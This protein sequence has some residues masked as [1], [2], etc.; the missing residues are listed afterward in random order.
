MKKRYK[1][2]LL[3]L[4]VAALIA[5]LAFFFLTGS[6]FLTSAVL[7]FLSSR[8]GV[9]ISAERVEWS[10]FRSRLSV[11]KLRV[12]PEEQPY[13]RAGKAEAH[14]ALSTLAGGALKL[15]GVRME[16]SELTLYHTGDGRWSIFH[17]SPPVSSPGGH[18]SGPSKPFAIDLKD[19]VFRDSRLRLIF[20]DPEAGSAL[21]LTGLRLTA[22]RFANGRPLRLEAEGDLRLASSRANH[23]DAGRFRLGFD[24]KLGAGLAPET[25][26]TSCSFSGLFG[27]IS[28]E[29]FNDG[30][31]ELSFEG[32]R[33]PDGVALKKLTLM[34]SQ[35][36]TQQSEVEI[37]GRVR[38]QPLEIEADI[39][40]RRLS[41]EVTSLLFDLGFG[42]NPG[43]AA[44]QYRGNFSYGKRKLVASGI[45]R[46]DRT[47]DAI[48]DLER[49]TLPPLRLDGE[50]DFAIDL[51]ESSIDL[52]KFAVTLAEKESE[53]ASFRLQRPIRYSWKE[54]AQSAGQRA[55]FDLEC[56][57]FDLKLL[58]FL[59]PGNSAFQF[60]SGYFTS[61][62]QLTLKHNLSAFS[63]LGT[64]RVNGSSCR[65]NGRKFELAEIIAGLDVELRRDFHWTLRNLSLALKNDDADLGSAN[66]SGEGELTDLAGAFSG[67]LEG[68]TPELAVWL[69]PALEPFLPEYRKL[70]LGAAEIVF[71]L[72][73][74]AQNE[75]LLLRRLEAGIDRDGVRALELK[76]G[77]YRF[78]AAGG[79]SPG[80]LKVQLTGELPVSAMNV[81]LGPRMR[82]GSG[83]VKLSAE[84]SV[85][86]SFRSAVFS[87]ELA[88]DELAA[89]AYGRDYRDFS[90]Q[91]AFS[92][93]MPT[94]SSIEF[95]TL[96]FYLRRLGK[97]ALR[98]ECPGTWDLGR[99]SYSGDWAI[100]YLND[101]FLTLLAPGTVSEAQL[102]GK[103]QVVARENFRV[104][105]GSGAL[106]LDKLVMPSQPG[107]VYTGSFS[108]MAEKDERR[109]LLRH[110]TA[111][112]K[113]GEAQLFD[114]AGECRADLSS[115]E[116]GVTVQLA[117]TAV[118]AGKL[119]ALFPVRS[120]GGTRKA[121]E[122]PRLDFGRRPVDLGCRL[123]RIRFTPALAVDLDTRIRLRT[124]SFLTD[125][126]LL[127]I[128]NARY[129]GEFH[130]SNTAK[131]ILFSA[132]LRGSEPLSLPPLMELIVGSS[133][134]GA[135]GTLR[136][137]NLNLRF[138]EDGRPD[139]YLE[140]MSGS[141]AMS[142]RN[143][144]IPN[145][146]TNGPF[147]RLLLFPIEMTGQLNSLLPEDIAAWKESVISSESLKK[148]L[149]MVRLDEGSVRLHANDGKVRVDECAFFGDW[150]SRL[151]FSGTFDL[152]GER[153]L[154]LVSKLTVGGIQTTIPIEGTLDN[155]LVHLESIATGS[156]GALLNKVK[157]LKL[158][159]TSADPSDPNKIE[160]VIMIDKLPSAGTIKELQK[161]F[162]GLWKN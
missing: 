38:F 115:P 91:C 143:L 96:N 65:W 106:D 122:V 148:Q 133:Q 142:F 137:F 21:E 138:L 45:L 49:I 11:D 130:G 78:G 99:A 92:C 128:N 53:A 160:P 35:G 125:H 95:R 75:P 74:A 162:K 61:R 84:G 111:G 140:T 81:Y 58:R 82:F 102:T 39:D 161:L 85:A 67:R 144:T 64:G 159:G 149:K 132:A 27:S 22:D 23:I 101:Q 127:Q 103:M 57:A 32:S 105:R 5:V 4:L 147:G 34:Q 90:A 136:E 17:G 86:H 28:G 83:K 42:F 117:S 121:D 30:A 126:L 1:I 108:L 2:T 77:P 123:Q 113:Q 109:L 46:A 10:L 69:C 150:V 31:L 60:D 124:G 44:L 25:F 151:A 131:G 73:K 129:D 94:M 3:T 152:A 20:G 141:L 139:S 156:L 6:F 157:E 112:L 18:A 12:G 87:G 155:P 37:S 16:Q 114:L 66:F 135:A 62:M 8:A 145:T 98:L 7:P 26:K 24:S 33:D 59:I 52:R 15:S 97:P 71:K 120:E 116:G 134:E 36:G 41:E 29:P 80:D 79:A 153:K 40:I 54:R 63:L 48:F 9:E 76:A 107:K 50:Y 19:V 154:D 55:V 104:L 110:I 89:R 118:D 56:S 100:R 47:G 72:E 14:Y 51:G 70:G 68:L 43:R 146:V 88:F 119:L 93:Y 13:F 158:I